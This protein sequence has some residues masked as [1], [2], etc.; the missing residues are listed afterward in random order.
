MVQKSIKWRQRSVPLKQDDY[1]ELSIQTEKFEYD[2]DW[3]KIVDSVSYD[4]ILK[5]L[6]ILK[7]SSIIIT[8]SKVWK[9]HSRYKHE[10]ESEN[11]TTYRY[12]GINEANGINHTINKEKE[13]KIL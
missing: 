7:I 8:F 6:N 3:L 5:V 2:L 11:H 1:G 4:W 12:L 13:E 9:H 10:N